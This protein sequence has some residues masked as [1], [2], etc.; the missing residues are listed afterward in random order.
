MVWLAKAYRMFSITT[1]MNGPIP[2]LRLLQIYLATCF[3]SHVT[4][5]SSGGTPLQIYLLHK[6][7][8]SL[9]K[10]TAVTVV[11][12]GLNTM[13]FIL[14]IPAAFFY[15]WSYF[16]GWQG[17]G[18][19]ITL[20]FRIGWLLVLVMLVGFIIRK[21]GY[22]PWVKKVT[23]W[24]RLRSF[25]ARKGWLHGLKQELFLFKDG[26]LLLF[27]ENPGS[28]WRA[29]S[30]SVVY[31]IGYL[32]LAP[33]VIWA[34]GRPVSFTS[35]IGL[36]LLFNFAQVFIPTPGG[37]GGS[38]FVLTYLFHEVTGP[39]WIGIFVLLW[40]IY[41]FYSTLLAGGICFLAV[42]RKM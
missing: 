38:E 39:A 4:P 32:L 15:N 23:G 1:G 2:L 16:R 40:K 28:L 30:A 18:W 29:I 22:W 21:M 41:T 37:S 33:M 11:D 25:L 17:G 26:W 24:N 35:L 6:Q 27:R 20:L 42:T 8:I 9:G 10:A 13:M 12:L 19:N 7:G 3:I 31:W 5:F 36:Q 14:L 34:I